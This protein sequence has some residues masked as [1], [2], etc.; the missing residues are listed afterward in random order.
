[1]GYASEALDRHEA[2]VDRWELEFDPRDDFT[3]WLDAD[4]AY[5]AWLDCLDMLR[6]E[7]LDADFA[8]LDEVPF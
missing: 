7:Q 1:M 8:D 2:E 4:P 3:R 6:L 5:Q